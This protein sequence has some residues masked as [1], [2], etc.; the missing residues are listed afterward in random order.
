[1]CL[2]FFLCVQL[3]IEHLKESMS[4]QVCCLDINCHH[5]RHPEGKLCFFF[6]HF[7]LIE[8][9][10]RRILNFLCS[11]CWASSGLV[12]APPAG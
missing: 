6:S 10:F 4:L 5:N 3:E 9:A 1:M 7:Y 8:V 2:P 11:T 12:L